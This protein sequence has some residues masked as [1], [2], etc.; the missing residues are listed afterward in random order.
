M[1]ASPL[2]TVICL[3]YNHA[4]YVVQTL[5]SVLTQSHPNIELLIVDDASTDDSVNVIENYLLEKSL[6]INFIK[7]PVNLGLTQSFN[8]A[9]AFAQGDF[10]IDLAADDVLFPHTVATQVDAFLN[11]NLETTAIVYGNAMNID[12]NNQFLSY[13]FEVDP[14]LKV[15]DQALH[16]TDYAR[17]LNTGKTFCSVSAMMNKKIFD[18]LKGYDNSL[19]FEDLDYWLRAAREYQLIFIDEVLIQKRRLLNSHGSQFHIKS[20]FSN[21]MDQSMLKIIQKALKMNRNKTEHRNLLKRINYSIV[22]SWQAHKYAMLFQFA[23]LKLQAH[24]KINT[25]KY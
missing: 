4:E 12:E 20:A 7:N 24:Y 13:F 18:T 25:T 10:L 22:R 11:S 2:V 15:H 17:I 21:Q 9:V 5:D 3:C 1:E 14:L 16:Q 19:A 8:K 23:W 6:S